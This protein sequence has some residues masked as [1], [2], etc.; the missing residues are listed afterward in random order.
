MAGAIREEPGAA[1][2]PDEL[3]RLQAFPRI[4]REAARDDVVDGGRQAGHNRGRARRRGRDGVE[5][6]LPLVVTLE[7]GRT[8]QQL[9]AD[10][11]QGVGRQMPRWAP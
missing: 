4:L 9:E 8:G 5:Q 10:D 3:V 1:Q 6:Q 11:A 7:R 2:R